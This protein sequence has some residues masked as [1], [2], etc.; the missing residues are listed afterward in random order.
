[1]WRWIFTV[2][3]ALTIVCSMVLWFPEW[4]VKQNLRQVPGCQPNPE[5]YT[6]LVN[7]SRASTIQFV[8]GLALFGGLIFTWKNYFLAEHGKNTDRFTNAIE[9]LG[10]APK[11]PGKIPG[12][13]H[14]G[15]IY[16][17][18]Q[19]A[20]DSK[21]LYWPCL[22]SMAGFLRIHPDWIPVTSKVDGLT[23]P[24]APIQAALEA[25]IFRLEHEHELRLDLSECNLAGSYCAR[26]SAGDIQGAKF[27]NC[28]LWCTDLS[29]SDLRQAQFS[30]ANCYGCKFTG[31][32][33]K[34]ADFTGVED[35]SDADFDGANLE[36]TKFQGVDLS[37]SLGLKTEQLAL[38][39]G[40]RETKLPDGVTPPPGWR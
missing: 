18:E 28:Y 3:V 32:K 6:R 25:I 38:A 19:L 29:A 21:L 35:L 24:P 33:L 31:A 16:A 10:A 5:H 15:G 13:S 20:R 34:D 11:E 2:A 4:A 9:L 14:L 17:L 39:I 30:H 37:K 12:V 26:R 23:H 22:Q 7:E 1:M 36:G 40:D 27:Q 8:G